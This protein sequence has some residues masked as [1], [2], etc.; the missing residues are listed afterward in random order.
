MN[1][2]ALS[3][4]FVTR[5]FRSRKWLRRYGLEL[6][7]TSLGMHLWMLFKEL[8]IDIVIDVGA[9]HGEYG[10]WLRRNGYDGWIHSFEPVA[11]SFR[12]L[13]VRSAT[14]DRWIVHPMALGSQ[15][16][17]SDINVAE[18][19]VFSSFLE[20]NAYASET[21]GS[22]PEVVATE[23]VQVGTLDEVFEGLVGRV[24][25]PQVYLKLDTQGWD[26]EV[27]RGGSQSLPQVL[28]L[29]TEI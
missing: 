8:D 14:D 7:R 20:P 27:L 21:F 22:S 17:Q 9:R 12:A 10:L 29:Q 4:Q 3:E 13:T 28:A 1:H 24:G 11:E 25:D 2:P 5:L 26:L 19:S 6:T 16:G 15:G 18:G 23:T